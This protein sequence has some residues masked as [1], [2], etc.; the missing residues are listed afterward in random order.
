MLSE[1][2]VPE[3]VPVNVPSLFM[4]HDEQVPSLG[5]AA[6]VCAVP[7]KAVPLWLIAREIVCRP[8]MFAPGPLQLPA[9][10]ITLGADGELLPLQA[11]MPMP[12]T[13]SAKA[14]LNVFMTRIPGLGP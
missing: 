1:T 13:A 3:M 5:S 9:S 12:A 4:W 8:S 14:I 6:L 10:D 2:V 11:A 7:D